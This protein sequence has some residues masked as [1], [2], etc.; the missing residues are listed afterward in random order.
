MARVS[1]K[2][3]R[4]RQY[5][6]AR[7]SADRIALLSGGVRKLLDSEMYA[8]TRARA[9]ANLIERREAARHA[10]DIMAS[11][12]TADAET[13]QIRALEAELD[14]LR[15]RKKR[16]FVMLRKTLDSQSPTTDAAQSSKTS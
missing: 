14:E 11:I 3:L 6:F 16:L 13:E 1:A 4:P 15:D 5:V 10:E 8:T 12:Q 2:A 7:L 9:S